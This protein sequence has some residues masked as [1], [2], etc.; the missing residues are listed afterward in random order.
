M[1]TRIMLQD[2]MQYA[3]PDNK[4]WL[5]ILNVLPLL[6]VLSLSFP[7]LPPSKSESPFSTGFIVRDNLR[8]RN[9]PRRQERSAQ[10]GTE[11]RAGDGGVLLELNEFYR[12][13]REEAA[14]AAK[15]GAFCFPIRRA[16]D[17]WKQATMEGRQREG[18][19]QRAW[20]VDHSKKGE[21][22][23][24]AGFLVE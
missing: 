13:R 20:R 11:D 9:R 12:I 4:A 15:A 14:E 16:G 6:V 17:V 19:V 21:G 10:P 3:S 18:R 23:K 5:C 1:L 8:I 7:S 22:R 24:G 2:D